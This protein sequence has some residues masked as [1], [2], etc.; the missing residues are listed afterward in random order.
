MRSP[1]RVSAAAAVAI[2]ASTLLTGCDKP[3][4]K[5]TVLGGGKVVNITPSTY[6]F[7]GKHCPRSK[8]LDLP[9]LTVAADEK[10]LIDVPRKVESRGWRA[11]ALTLDGSKVLGTSGAIE[12]SHSYRVPS[13]IAQGDAFIVQ[14]DELKSGAPDGSVWSFLVKV[15]LTAS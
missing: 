2:T 4:P 1:V 9:T 6:C 14:I 5:V 8:T 7:D 15:S 11:Q 3:P 12:H 10:V 13:G